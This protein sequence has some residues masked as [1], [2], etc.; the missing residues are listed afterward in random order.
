MDVNGA[1]QDLMTNINDAL[2]GDNV[3]QDIQSAVWDML[4][5]INIEVPK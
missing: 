4:K 5:K 2:E 3:A 1:V